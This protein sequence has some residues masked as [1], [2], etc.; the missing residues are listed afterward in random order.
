MLTGTTVEE[1]DTM[2]YFKDT[3]SPQEYD[4]AI[5]RLQNQYIK[6]Y[7]DGDK[8]IK[9]NMKPQT[10]LVDFDPSRMFRMQELKSLF[11]ITN[12]DERGNDRLEERI[13][14][15][16]AISPIFVLNQNKMVEVTPANV[17]EEVINYSRNKSILDEALDIPVDNVLLEISAIRALIESIKP[18]DAKKG[19]EINANDDGDG[20]DIDI[21]TPDPTPTGD[22]DQ[23][24][25]DPEEN[26]PSTPDDDKEKE[27]AKKLVAYYTRILFYAFLTKT[28]VISLSQVI[29]SI[30]ANEDNRRIAQHTAIKIEDLR[31]IFE[32]ASH[33]KLSHLDGKIQNINSLGRDDSLSPIERATT[34]MRKFARISDSEV[35]TPANVA[36]DLVALIPKDLIGNESVF[37]DLSSKQGEIACALY[38]RYS[39]DYP[40]IAQN[41]A[42]QLKYD[43][44][45]KFDDI[46]FKNIKVGKLIS[47][48]EIQPVFLRLDSELADKTKK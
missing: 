41:M 23:P 6:S 37:I 16:L 5:F 40:N 44:K 12:L 26:T 47:K 34:A 43:I 36:N 39:E 21:P 9:F 33:F 10:L 35:V 7:R 25:S 27:L 30:S 32:N 46:D 8:V 38:R 31:L 48:E 22:G 42:K 11:Y 24:S 19:L 18:I 20:T 28:K 3:A 13:A 29:D 17:I 45:T 2:L 15:E 14:K 4:Q 1:W